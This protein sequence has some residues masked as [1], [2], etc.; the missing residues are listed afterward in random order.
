M[1]HQIQI[2]YQEKVELL[3]KL[4]GLLQKHDNYTEDNKNNIH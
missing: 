1:N 3:R 4:Y 2:A